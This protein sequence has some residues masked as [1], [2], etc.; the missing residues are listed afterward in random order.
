LSDPRLVLCLFIALI[1]IVVVINYR[2]V[3]RRMAWNPPAPDPTRTLPALTVIIPARDEEADLDQSLRSVLAQEGIDLRVIVVNDHSSDR[4]GAIADAFAV[5]DPRVSVIHNPE[6]PAGWLGKCNAMQ[7]AAAQ[8]ATD[9]LLFTDADI[10]YQPGCL[11]R[12]VTELE[13]D[14]LEFLS[15]FPCMDFISVWENVLVPAMVGGLCELMTPGVNDPSSPDA[16]GAGA[17]LLVRTR[18]FRAVGGFEPIKHEMGDDVALARLLKRSGCHTA[19][20]G[21]PDWLSVRLYKGN[22]HAFWGMTKNILI[23]L[24]GRF[25]MA[26]LIFA[27]PIFV[28][29]TPIYCFVA[30]VVERNAV[31]ALTA[32][33][34]Y[35]ILY[36]E[37]W[38]GRSLLRLHRGKALLFPLVVAPVAC[39]LARALYLHYCKGAVHWRGRTITVRQSVGRSSSA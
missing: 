10:T 22:H 13:R 34:A 33:A 3:L 21:A 7:Q 17:F 11:I 14:G 25:W 29:W 9:L 39:C 20:H 6:L 18:A 1:A 27:L 30:A 5:A 12:A 16:M 24:E 35:G 15:L 31:L 36:L 19:F 38:I 4:T 26:P 23:G 32:A 2:A 28:Y 37:L 8:A